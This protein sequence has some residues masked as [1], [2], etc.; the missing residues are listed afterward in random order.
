MSIPYVDI[1]I[2]ALVAG[3]ILLRLRSI[4]GQDA[5]FDGKDVDKSA[6]KKAMDHKVLVLRP[7]D[8]VQPKEPEEPADK[9][10]LDSLSQPLQDAV[11][12]IKAV[13]KDFDLEYFIGGA[14]GAF[15]MVLKA[16]NENDAETLKHL[17]ADDIEEMFVAEARARHE[18]AT[19]L[20]T[21]LVSIAQVDI[22]DIQLNKKH[23][24]ITLGFTSEQVTVERDKDGE[25][26]GGD[27]KDVQ[28]VEDEWVF[29]RDLGSRSPNWIITAT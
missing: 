17:L 1:I 22:R 4:L 24:T 5:G 13:E 21:T 27:A 12:Q 14:K 20:D 29:E 6:P 23:A 18:A 8:L 10:L 28:R 25:M 11:R 9:A 19:K 2:M 26:I 15:E 7:G 3:F 16:F